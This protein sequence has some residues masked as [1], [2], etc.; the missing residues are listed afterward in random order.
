M[1]RSSLIEL[2][3]KRPLQGHIVELHVLSKNDYKDLAQTCVDPEIWRST[4]AKIRTEAELSD[5]LDRGLEQLENGTAVP[6]VIRLAGSGTAVGSTRLA[7]TGEKHELEIG[8]TFIAPAWHRRGINAEAKLLLLQYAF[9]EVGC[10]KVV[11]KVAE[12]NSRSQA[13]LAALGAVSRPSEQVASTPQ[14]HA[15][16]WFEISTEAWADTRKSLEMRVERASA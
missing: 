5:Y 2:V 16:Q 15:V 14:G 9:D 3:H 8:W 4:I 11:F 7:L 10:R 13:A 1:D 12:G 6:F